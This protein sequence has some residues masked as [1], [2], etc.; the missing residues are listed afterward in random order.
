MSTSNSV[1]DTSP[2]RAENP[3]AFVGAYRVV[4]VLGRGGMATVYEVEEPRTGTRL[5]LK[6]LTRRGFNTGRFH[7]EYRSLVRLDHPNIVRVLHLGRASGDLPFI[8]M[9]LLEGR[10][11]QAYVKSVGRPGDEARTKAV[12]RV[13]R[14]VLKALAYLHGRH[15]LHRDVKSSN[16]MVLN[17]GRVKLLDLG[18]ARLVPPGAQGVYSPE[19]VGTYAYA[20]PE[21]IRGEPLDVRSDLYACGVLAYRMLTGKQPFQADTSHDVARLHLTWYPPPPQDVVTALPLPLSDLVMDLIDKDPERRPATAIHVLE[22]LEELFPESEDAPLGAVA[23]R[24]PV[25]DDRAFP[26]A[27]LVRL[28]EGGGAGALFV[29]AGRPGDGVDRALEQAAERLRALGWKVHLA[30]DLG[31]SPL[32]ALGCALTEIARTMPEERGRLLQALQGI[33]GPADLALPGACTSW[34]DAAL[35]V[36]HLWLG[37]DAGIPCQGVVL[38]PNLHL[39]DDGLVGLLSDLR[40]AAGRAALP[41][42]FVGSV[43]QAGLPALADLADLAA[44]APWIWVEPM[45]DMDALRFVGGM[46]EHRPVPAGWLRLAREL[47]GGCAGMLIDVTYDSARRN[48]LLPERQRSLVVHWRSPGDGPPPAP[49]AIQEPLL[50]HLALV[51]EHERRWLELLAMGGGSMPLEVLERLLGRGQAQTQA[52]A[53]RLVDRGLLLRTADGHARLTC[54]FLRRMVQERI[55]ASRRAL[56]LQQLVAQGAA[57]L[58]GPDRARLLLE[59]G[60]VEEALSEAVRWCEDRIEHGD[61]RVVRGFLADHLSDLERSTNLPHAA[62]VRLVVCWARVLRQVRGRAEEADGAF[63]WASDQ[64]VGD[65]DLAAHVAWRRGEDDLARGKV[66]AAERSLSAAYRHFR[67]TGQAASACLAGTSLGRALARRRGAREAVTW[68]DGVTSQTWRGAEPLERLYAV[69][70]ARCERARQRLT[71]GA[72]G[73][74]EREARQVGAALLGSGRP[75]GIAAGVTLLAEVLRLKARFTEAREVLLDALYLLDG[76]EDQV[77]RSRVIL[78]LAMLDVDL[79]RLGM[80]RCRIEEVESNGLPDVEVEVEVRFLEARVALTCGD[81][82]AARA[83]AERGLELAVG[84]ALSGRAHALRALLAVAASRAG[85]GEEARTALGHSISYLAVRREWPDL[86]FASLCSSRVGGEGQDPD[87][88]FGPV[89]EWMCREPAELTRLWWLLARLA[90]A[91]GQGL[92]DAREEALMRARAQ[93]RGIGEHLDED[94]EQAVRAHPAVRRVLRLMRETQDQGLDGLA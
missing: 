48:Y 4:R 91:E 69:A 38:V 17:D 5:A 43:V 20:S 36:L 22:R 93:I 25:L 72:L 15:L 45:G 7:A 13:Y 42:R 6:L 68:L 78:A 94:D 92:G 88:T 85:G 63:D 24:P 52:A 18:T 44:D 67:E 53:A 49:V 79:N 32:G 40:Q 46:L 30:E 1:M 71:L 2:P 59:A 80:A 8:T 23:V 29:V 58:F 66:E 57:C 77:S 12:V 19:F 62:T 9:E 65:L 76:Q 27:R 31:T 81:P 60:R 73:E 41:V 51:D 90:W 70:L 83:A 75:V 16:A 37:R 34:V 33:V 64:A 10:S 26:T 50:T 39:L 61:H 86:A 89:L 47:T 55:P 84:A 11:L 35:R 21:Q 82:V 87:V 54:G 3:P 14:C 56:L 74:A 28:L